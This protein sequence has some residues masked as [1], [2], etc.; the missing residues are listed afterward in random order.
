V[1]LH[2]GNGSFAGRRLVSAENLAVTR[3]SKV[4]INETT[5]YA[6]GWIVVDTPNGRV[7]WH[8]GGTDGFGALIGFLPHKQ[9]GIIILTNQG[10]KGFPDAAGLW[11]LDKLLGNPETDHVKAAL[12]HAK[13]QAEKQAALYRKRAAPQPAPAVD[14]LVGQYHSDPLGPAKLAGDSKEL[15]LSLERTGAQ[16]KLEPFDGALFTVKLVPQ[17]SYASAAAALGSD[18]V[19]FAG[20]EADAEGRRSR[21]RWISEGQTYLWTRT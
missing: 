13:D 3:T 10:N 5:N 12:A 7:V 15:L 19:G 11:A 14:I 18:P 20:F 8:N 17:G 16:L 9:V 6:M 2:L 1:S 21:L 4:A